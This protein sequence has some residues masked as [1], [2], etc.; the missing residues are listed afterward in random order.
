MI[1]KF[2]I[3]GCMRNVNSHLYWITDC[4]SSPTSGK[5]LIDNVILFLATI[6][7]PKGRP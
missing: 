6:F 2:H 7:R 3:T 4:M 1:A 5:K